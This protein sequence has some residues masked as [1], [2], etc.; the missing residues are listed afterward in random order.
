M[1]CAGIMVVITS[2]EEAEHG[3]VADLLD[4]TPC[5]GRRLLVPLVPLV[6]LPLAIPTCKTFMVNAS[7]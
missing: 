5:R 3:K 1:Q 2:L 4:I 7:T 6:R